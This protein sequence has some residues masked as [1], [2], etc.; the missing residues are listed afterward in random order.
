MA[1][2]TKIIL[3]I[4]MNTPFTLQTVH[5]TLVGIGQNI[6]V[7]QLSPDVGLRICDTVIK[8]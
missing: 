6:Y 2:N 4:S 5:P 7:L 8:C 3:E 1:R